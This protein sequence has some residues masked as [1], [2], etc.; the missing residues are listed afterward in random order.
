MARRLWSL[1]ESTKEL[2]W[3]FVVMSTNTVIDKRRSP[4]NAKRDTG[5]A[6]KKQ[7]AGVCFTKS[8][9]QGGDVTLLRKHTY[10]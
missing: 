7:T 6:E 9:P 2:I 5:T 8:L 1:T 10:F 3:R 4:I